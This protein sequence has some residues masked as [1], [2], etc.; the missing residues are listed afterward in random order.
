MA[1]W[2]TCLLHVCSLP[3]DFIKTRMQKMSPNPDGTM[4]YANG[5]DCVMKTIRQEGPLTFY[6]GFPTY[7]TRCL[8][9]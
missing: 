6:T 5:V 7:I 9:M 8:R 1:C 3:F 2:L 4:P